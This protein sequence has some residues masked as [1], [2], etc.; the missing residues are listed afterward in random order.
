MKSLK[1]FLLSLAIVF[2]LT[3]Y[4]SCESSGGESS[5]PSSSSGCGSHNGNTL[6]LGPQGGCYYLNSSGNKVYVD[7][8]ECN[9]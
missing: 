9:C 6:H 2:I 5:I 1:S 7:R 3:F 4:F 8:S